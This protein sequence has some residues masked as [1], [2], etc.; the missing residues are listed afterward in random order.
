MKILTV[1]ID[2]GKGGTQ[3]AAQNFCEGYASLGHD[4][5]IMAVGRDG[6]RREELM[7]EHIS[8]WSGTGD[9]VLAEVS[10]WKPDVVHL[11]SIALPT[12]FVLVL[13]EVCKGAR[14]I[15]TNVFSDFS[16]YTKYLDYSFQLSEWCAYNYLARGGMKS[17]CVI[18]PNPVKTQNF[19][20]V[21]G[22]A[23]TAFRK[24]YSIPLET[25]LFG[26]VGQN[27]LDK[28][29]YYLIDVF[30]EFCENVS[31]QCLLLVVNPPAQ[32]V[33][34]ARTQD[35]VKRMVIID[36]LKG[37][38]ELRVCYSSIDTFLHIANQ[39]ESFG[40]V[41]AESLLCET[42][43]ITL[44]TPWSDNSQGEVVGNGVGGYCVNTVKQFVQRM[45]ILYRDPKLREY[46]GRN[47]RTSILNRYGYKSVAARSIKLLNGVDADQTY[48][49]LPAFKK[50]ASQG[51][52][53]NVLTQLLLWIKLRCFGRQSHGSKA[54][55]I[56]NLLLRKLSG[57]KLRRKIIGASR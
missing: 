12:D 48:L 22:A 21:E 11:H 35:V 23:Q 4:S 16:P 8:I 45:T 1:V 25:F 56:I 13:R 28:W 54:H 26:R 44:N 47:G 49:G 39:G 29:S 24:K 40:L 5:R 57:Y 50:L 41:L 14:F 32:I 10:L 30:K 55:R 7:K 38:E 6:V 17:K 18:I 43:V 53:Y 15:E 27:L 52:K 34:Y 46:M 33:E 2:L 51:I 20:K 31:D 3:R 19:F 36:E 42:A 9:N 37:D